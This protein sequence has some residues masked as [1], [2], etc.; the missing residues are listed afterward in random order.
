MKFYAFLPFVL[1][2]A[3]RAARS[4]DT[5][6]TGRY[7]ISDYVMTDSTDAGAPAGRSF[8]ASIY[9][10][11]WHFSFYGKDS[12]AV[13]PLFGM[14]YLG[15]SLFRYKLKEDTLV[16]TH[17][18]NVRKLPLTDDLGIIRLHNLNNDIASFAMI[19]IKKQQ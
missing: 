15:D 13:D 16:L 11:P 10:S 8:V 14:K 4:G 9:R 17:N 19:K 7:T 3:C 2:L 6:L 18:K 5:K 1:F 12:V